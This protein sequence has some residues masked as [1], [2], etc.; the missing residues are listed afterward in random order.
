MAIY[1]FGTM[2]RPGASATE[3]KRIISTYI[4]NLMRRIRD[5][6]DEPASSLVVVLTSYTT[7]AK[8]SMYEKF[9]STDRHARRVTRANDAKLGYEDDIDELADESDMEEEDVVKLHL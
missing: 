3:G 4:R 1:Y 5:L 8:R 7:W 6:P 9:D 2:N